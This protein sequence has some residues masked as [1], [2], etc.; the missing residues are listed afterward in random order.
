MFTGTQH[1]MQIVIC[2][3]MH[4]HRHVSCNKQRKQLLTQGVPCFVIHQGLQQW[5]LHHNTFMSHHLGMRNWNCSWHMWGH[6]ATNLLGIVLWRNWN[7]LRWKE[8]VINHYLRHRW[9]G[10]WIL[11]ICHLGIEAIRRMQSKRWIITINDLKKIKIRIAK[12]LTTLFFTSKC[13]EEMRIN[14]NASPEVQHAG[15]QH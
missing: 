8:L 12:N 2:M 15:L 6:W 10:R 7:L 14:N 5:D 9:A 3:V 13:K 1:P 4:I 11:S